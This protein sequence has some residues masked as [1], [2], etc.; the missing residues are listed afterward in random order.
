[1]EINEE[2][3]NELAKIVG[4]AVKA[5]FSESRMSSQV[6]P[7]Q[8]IQGISEFMH[9]LSSLGG[10]DIS[11]GVEAIKQ[12][13]LWLLKQRERSEKINTFIFF[14]T[15]STIIGGVLTSIW[16]GIKVMVNTK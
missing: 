10:G 5:Q 7:P 12:N 8:R 16:A 15:V 9:M 1:M 14:L 4:E 2:L 3:K 13:N 6:I 11:E